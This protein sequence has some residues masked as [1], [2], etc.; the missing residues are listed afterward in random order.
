MDENIGRLRQVSETLAHL[1][2]ANGGR[3]YI[4]TDGAP[5]E[6]AIIGTAESFLGL[7]KALVDF[8]YAATAQQPDE[9]NVGTDEIS[10]VPLLYTNEIKRHIDDESKVW[11]V[12][13][14][15]CKDTEAAQ[16]VAR[17]FLR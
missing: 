15:L 14:Y 11:L 7:A 3:C 8:V 6:S 16:R 1:I 13:A 5:D 17:S 9:M 4:E 2:H 12:V 10:G